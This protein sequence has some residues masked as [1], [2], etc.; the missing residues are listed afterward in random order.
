[1]G[2]LLSDLDLRSFGHTIMLAGAIYRGEGRTLIALFPDDQAAFLAEEG[3]L[4]TLEMNL[5]GWNALLQQTDGLLTEVDV[6]T[7]DGRIV[8]AIARKCERQIAQEVSWRVYRR[9]GYRCRYCGNDRTPLTVDHLVLWEEGGPSVDANLLSACRQCNKTR[10][11][12]PYRVWIKEDPYYERVSRKL[13]FAVREANEALI[14]TLDAIPR[15]KI[16]TR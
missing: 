5:D 1:M 9:D 14:A 16:R 15:G 6:G 4:D 7:P 10:G 8:K 2:T 13:P 3:G 12:T 11:R